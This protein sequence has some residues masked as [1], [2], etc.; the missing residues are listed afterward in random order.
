MSQL[1]HCD[2]MGG[3]SCHGGRGGG[4]GRPAQTYD[5]EYQHAGRRY[6]RGIVFKLP[7]SIKNVGA[8]ALLKQLGDDSGAKGAKAEQRL[9]ELIDENAQCLELPDAALIA[10]QQR[11]NDDSS[12]TLIDILTVLSK[13]SGRLFLRAKTPNLQTIAPERQVVVIL[14][15]EEPAPKRRRRR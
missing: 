15:P 12:T 9:A 3:W 2:G 8:A 1:L 4:G 5:W 13:A 14:P 11:T 7:P 6:G 10:D